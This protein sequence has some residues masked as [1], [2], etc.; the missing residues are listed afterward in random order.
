MQD[1]LL[2]PYWYRIA[3][4]H[5]RLR[6]HV[7]VRMQTTRG[8]AWY[9][10]HNHASGR[11]HRVNVHA[12]ELVGR[13]DGRLTVD[14]IWKF[15]L[16]NLGDDAPSQHEVIRI[17]GQMTDAGLVQAEVT[18]DVR[19][20]LALDAERGQQEKRGRLNPL[21]FR[22]GLFNPSALLDTLQPLAL[23][24]FKPWVL[25]CWLM[26][27]AAAAVVTGLNWKDMVP[28]AQVHFM[29]PGFLAA[30]WVVYPLMKALHELGH[31][32]A[33]RR[34]FC[35]VPEVGVNFFMF[36]PLPYVDASSSNRLVSRWQ[37]AQISAAGIAVELGLAAVAVGVWMLVEDGWVR[38]LAFVMMTVG[39]LSTLLFNGN[40][41]MKF[42]GYFVLCD[43]LDLP[44]LSQRSGRLFGQLLRKGAMHLLRVDVPPNLSGAHGADRVERLA[45]WLY[46]PLSW[47]Y[48]VAVSAVMVSWTAEKSV[49]LGLGILGWSVW[50]LLLSPVK[51]WVDKLMQEP[52]FERVLGRA[53]FGAG[54][55]VLFVG[56]CIALVP[57]PSSMVVEGVV[58]LPEHAQVRAA[59]DGQVETVWVRSGQRVVA[60]QALVSVLDPELETRKAV[61]LA[62]IDSSENEINGTM[63]SAALR[64]RNAQDALIRDRAALAQVELDLSRQTIRAGSH[65]EFV[66]SRQEDLDERQVN[67]GEVLAYVLGDE[68]AVVR[69]VVPQ[70][71][72]D[73]VRHRVKS[74]S[75]MLDEMPGRIWPAHMIGSV[76]GA[77]GKLPDKALGDKAGG[78]V[79][80]D[81]ADPEGLRPIE[82]QFVIDV[83]LADRLPRAGGLARVRIDLS[84]QPLLT[85][86][87][88]SARQLFLRHFS[89]IKA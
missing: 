45:L 12:Y 43:V 2:S 72:V 76:P 63:T 36:V 14:E 80:T 61:L 86:W 7:T 39:G 31:A 17:L 32:L 1:T 58:W 24:M 71:S 60:G 83:A 77:A 53:S 33:L 9:M 54:V 67:R 78:R 42:D 57:L 22:L 46:A 15:L 34:F 68:N 18:P 82:P 28:Y 75:V 70:H 87:V 64:M 41:L 88:H 81:G 16:D 11:F 47:L 23:L 66:L 65:G 55:L 49:W 50:T 52:G 13:M 35:E 48:R 56:A 30:A 25:M 29:T 84:A 21:A 62:Q 20:M 19:Q 85:S 40:P 5:P 79:T 27:V 10:L 59:S 69:A 51:F 26:M 73:A 44:N 6:P 4:L 8:Q 74:M 3:G 37:R 38:Q 89:D